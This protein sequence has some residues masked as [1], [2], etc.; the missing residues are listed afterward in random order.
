MCGFPFAILG[1]WR[2]SQ[3]TLCE[4][5]LRLLVGQPKVRHTKCKGTCVLEDA[6]YYRSRG[7]TKCRHHHLENS[8]L[9]ADFKHPLTSRSW[10]WFQLPNREMAVADC[11]LS[12]ELIAVDL[13]SSF[14]SRGFFYRCRCPMWSSF[15]ASVVSHER[16]PNTTKSDPRRGSPTKG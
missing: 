14:L 11:L 12:S 13:N 8:E 10:L 3:P 16:I 1:S 6:I 5:C 2:I 4:L 7:G 15:R 9:K